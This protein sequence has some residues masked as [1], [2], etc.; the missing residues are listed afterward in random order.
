[1]V[2]FIIV[3]GTVL[4]TIFSPVLFFMVIIC[5]IKKKP[6]KK[7]LIGLFVCIIF[8][9]FLLFLAAYL[10]R[11]DFIEQNNIEEVEKEIETVDENKETKLLIENDIENK[12]SEKEVESEPV[13][14]QET[15]YENEDYIVNDLIL[16]YNE[17][18]IFP[19][20]NNFIE[21]MEKVGRPIE[22]VSYTF[23]NGVYSILRYNDYNKIVFL[24]LQVE[25]VDSEKIKQI[26]KDFSIAENKNFDTNKLDEDWEDFVL[27][28]VVFDEYGYDFN[29][30]KT[31][32]TSQKR[33]GGSIFYRLRSRYMPYEE[34]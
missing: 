13:E 9:F 4:F 17:S 14:K 15:L 18:A 16:K 33:S 22:T 7:F 19:Y 31:T 23:E 8:S 25:D 12:T 6:M 30:I 11:S 10:I 26:F 29:G 24:E 27:G 3:F 21:G 5:F 20:G 28:N 32:L 1:M 2:D 34:E